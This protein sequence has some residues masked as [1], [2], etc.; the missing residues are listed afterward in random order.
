MQFKE[1]NDY[2]DELD[3]LLEDHE[4]APMVEAGGQKHGLDVL[5]AITDDDLAPAATAVVRAL[6]D[7]RDANPSVLYVI[8]IGPSVP[9]AVVVAVTLEEELRNPRTRA[10][11]EAE[12]RSILDLSDG[13]RAAWPFKIEVG[14]VA[15]TIVENARNQGIDMIVMGLNRHAAVARIMGKDTV[16]EVMA[17]VGVPV[18]E[19]VQIQFT[20]RS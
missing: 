1:K 8:E 20:A 6:Q 17:L 5:L 7:R 16:R 3:A 18:L 9:E 15:A 14:S 2:S 13:A 19:K 4:V 10:K 12:M 11:Q